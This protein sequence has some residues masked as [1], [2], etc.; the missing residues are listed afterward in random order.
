MDQQLVIGFDI[1]WIPGMEKG[2]LQNQAIT[3]LIK[4]IL[5]L[6]T[7]LKRLGLKNVK[8]V[9]AKGDELAAEVLNAMKA[10]EGINLNATTFDNIIIL[11][12]KEVVEAESFAVIRDGKDNK[13]PFI[14]GIDA[15]QLH[16]EYKESMDN[17][18]YVCIVEMIAIALEASV[19]VD[20]SKS[21]L[22]SKLDIQNKIIIFTPRAEVIMYEM[23]RER[24]KAY[25]ELLQA[26]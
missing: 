24:Y 22:V 12:N 11:A 16:K 6:E 19:G 10:Q 9:R 14:A 2:D 26:A 25:I 21:P 4:E 1:S 5:G 17:Q 7:T 13:K 20:V 18:L 3:P 23:L 15:V 8:V